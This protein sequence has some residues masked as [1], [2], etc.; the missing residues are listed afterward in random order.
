[1]RQ[2]EIWWANLAKPIGRR[3]VLL[4]S[5]NEACLIRSSVTI[6]IVTRTIHNILVEVSLGPAQGLPKICVANLDTIFT[7]EKAC[8]DT[9]I[10]MLSDH[11]WKEVV[12]ALKFALNIP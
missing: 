12:V 3:P 7:I 11:K 9:R 10:C 1:M 5:R 6:A 8:F 2:G 4:L